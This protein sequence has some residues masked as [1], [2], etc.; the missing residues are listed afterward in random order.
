M[1]ENMARL[2][3]RNRRILIDSCTV[4]VVIKHIFSNEFSPKVDTQQILVKIF[5]AVVLDNSSL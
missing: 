3:F 4:K 1:S 2:D 5:N